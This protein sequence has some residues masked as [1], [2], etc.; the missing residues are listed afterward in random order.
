MLT[1]RQKQILDFI[2]KFVKEKDYAPSLEEIRRH[3]KLAKSTVHQH[4]ET[5]RV[6][7]YLNKIE[8]QPRSIELN[9]K[10]KISDLVEIPLLGTIAAGEPIE[11]FENKETIEVPKSQLS[12]SGEH[13]ALRV[14]GD[15]MINE[16]IFDGSTVIIRKQPDAENGE[17]VV[18]LIN[19]NE[20]TLKKIYKEKDGFRLQPANPALK[21]IF[22][23]ELEIQGKVV[24][25][26]RSFEEL[27]KEVSI[28]KKKIIP[29]SSY[30]FT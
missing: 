1:K 16:G 25:V 29:T 13:F 3:F 30:R 22:V 2:E 27:K 14:S 7:G 10:K 28:E 20:V 12:K 19:G 11:V 9:Q 5:L 23:K 4:I 8:N 26:I 17:T 24:S 6:K 18:A 21:P 15:S